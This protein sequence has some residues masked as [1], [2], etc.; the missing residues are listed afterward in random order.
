MKSFADYN[1]VRAQ[2][3][4]EG[5]YAQE[6]KIGELGLFWLENVDYESVFDRIKMLEEEH[7]KR[8]PHDDARRV[9]IGAPKSKKPFQTFFDD[10][11]RLVMNR[12]G[13]YILPYK[14]ARLDMENP[15]RH[16]IW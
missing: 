15:T 1:R 8:Q 2:L 4:K 13:L 7:K 11:G 10:E 3:E 9:F 16:Y 12:F 5:I 14:E 6:K